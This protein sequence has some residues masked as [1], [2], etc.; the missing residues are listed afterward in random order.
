LSLLNNTGPT[1]EEARHGQDQINHGTTDRPGGHRFR[2]AAHGSSDSLRQ[3]INQINRITGMKVR[4]ATAELEPASGAVVQAFTTGTVVQVFL[5][6]GEAPTE[7]WRSG[8]QAAGTKAPPRRKR[9][10]DRAL[11]EP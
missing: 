9:K 11:P 2:A 6:G 8:D 5:L 7:S 1:A 3:E 4:E 10:E